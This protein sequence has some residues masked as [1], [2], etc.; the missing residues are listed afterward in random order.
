MQLKTSIHD[1]KTVYCGN[2]ICVIA[3]VFILSA[4]YTY[5]L[6]SGPLKIT[7]KQVI[8]SIEA[9]LIVLPINILLVQVS[10]INIKH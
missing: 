4:L 1:V 5:Y 9:T 10:A 3:N 2:L 7:V 8:I 6:V